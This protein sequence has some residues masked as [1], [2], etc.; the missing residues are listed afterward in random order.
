[1]EILDFD[2]D[3]PEGL[4]VERASSEG[5][6]S[7]IDIIGKNA[8]S[9]S[10]TIVKRAVA[11]GF[12]EAKRSADRVELDRGEQRLLVVYDSEGLTIQTYDPTVLRTARVDGPFV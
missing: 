5:D 3:L 8:E 10:R 2:I 1:M 7:C 12:S 6:R 11:A 4:R 9:L